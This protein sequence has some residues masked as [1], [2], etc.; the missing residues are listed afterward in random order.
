[1]TMQVPLPFCVYV[2]ISRK[3]YLLYIG[4]T[5]N[6]NQRIKEHANGDTKSTSPRRPLELIYCEF[7]SNKP[8]AMRREGYFKTSAGKRALNLM[9]REALVLKDYKLLTD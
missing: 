9:L 5:T 7:H 2:L 1:M 3:D 6:L 4:Y 8:D